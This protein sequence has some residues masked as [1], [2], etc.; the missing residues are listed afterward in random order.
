MLVIIHN[1][2][3]RVA[4]TIQSTKS[5]T[6]PEIVAIVM[7]ELSAVIFYTGAIIRFSQ[8]RIGA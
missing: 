6:D 1:F 3:L 8:I 4:K 7:S 2:E 5:S